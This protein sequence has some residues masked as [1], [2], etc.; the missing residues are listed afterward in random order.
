[1]TVQKILKSFYKTVDALE[2]LASVKQH[3]VD[4]CNSKIAVLEEQANAAWDERKK[5]TAVAIKIQKL[6]E[7]N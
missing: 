4:Q 2:K 6:L 5:A 3:E 7:D 1:M